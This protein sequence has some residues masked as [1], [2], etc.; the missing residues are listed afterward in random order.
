MVVVELLVVVIDVEVLVE[1]VLDVVVDVDPQGHSSVTT[2]PTA[3][4]RHSKASVADTGN[5]PFGAQRHSVSQVSVPTAAPRMNRQS[6]AVGNADPVTGA[7]HPSTGRVVLVEVE[8]VEDVDEV[9]VLVE[10]G[11]VVV[12]APQPG[13]SGSTK[14]ARSG[15]ELRVFT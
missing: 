12:V 7:A 1:L 2:S 5:D 13:C 4:R 14:N 3:V 8:T 9:E 15:G 11:S 10:L 6:V